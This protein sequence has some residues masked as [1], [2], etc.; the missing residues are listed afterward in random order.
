M[1]LTFQVFLPQDR[2]S[3]KCEIV[4]RDGGADGEIKTTFRHDLADAKG[5]RLVARQVSGRFGLDA[6]EVERHLEAA[7]ATARNEHEQEAAAKADAP[8]VAAGPVYH[9]TDGYLVLVR[10]TN[11][12]EVTI[13]L[14]RFTA[15]IVEQTVIDDGV[16]RR[17][18]LA[19]EGRLAD[20]TPLPRAEV[21]ARD[22][23]WVRWPVEMW[24]TR[25]VVLAGASTADHL[26]TA[27]QILS[28]DVPTRTVYAHLGWRELG[29]QW[30]YLHAAGAIGAAGPVEGIEVQVPDSLAGYVLPDPPAGEA[31]V[32]A[33]RASLRILEVAPDRLAVPLL[34]AVH[35]GVLAPADYSLHVAGLT[36]IGKTELAALTQQHH[37]A[38]LDS[39]HLPGSWTSTGNSLES[40]AF[41]AKDS[42]L[43]VD[44]F[45]PSGSTYD[46][47][48]YHREAD[49]FLRAQGNRA[50]RGRCRVDGTVRPSRPP[51]GTV[52]STGEDVPRG[53]S[54]RARLLTLN[55]SPGELDWSLLTACQ[56]DAAAGLYAEALAGYLRWLA[57]RYQAVR[58]GLRAEMAALRERVQ[59]AGMNARTPGIIADLA[60]GWRW[61]LDFAVEVGAVTPA[62]R[63]VLDARVWAALLVAGAEQAAHAEASDPVMR[64]L[65]LLAGTLAS[66]RAHVAGPDGDEPADAGSWG[67][68]REEYGS[69]DGL[70]ERWV[71]QG[72]RI[73]W[74]DGVEAQDLY[75]EPEATYATVQQLAHE[76]GESLPV[77]EHTLRRRLHER[78]L[79]TTTGNRS[80]RVQLTARR[81]LEG[82]RREV[83]HIRADSVYTSHTTTPCTP[84][85]SP[86]AENGVQ[87]WGSSPPAMAPVP[88]TLPHELP[89][90]T[91]S[92]ATPPDPPAANG[93]HGVVPC[94]TDIPGAPDTTPP[95]RYRGTL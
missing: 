26:R 23:S 36:Q 89:R 58:D 67:W 33:I 48:R 5:R 73:G 28:G 43:T 45:A 79:L 8:P 88:H 87:T 7:F 44:D 80:G 9:D 4:V 41:A 18:V 70:R 72:R 11:D 90:G 60:I 66:G 20:G 78:G 46:V 47:Q 94:D 24:G 13:P 27:I 91:A 71:S 50:G 12:G 69:R 19:I 74:V 40:L 81:V 25:A 29:G 42:L 93:V 10:P 35:R 92:L 32:Q 39:R 53:Q 14:A 38:G 56:R 61:W 65:A 15:R 76:Q 6:T 64:W 77:S 31:L 52:L 21:P 59:V 55:M 82:V 22:Y 75:L 2:R 85:A 95:R 17:T 62:E 84:S 57:P 54:L 51:R 1:N 49:R 68:R 34:G 3:R 16:E 63:E 30:V 83:L 86:A 37:G